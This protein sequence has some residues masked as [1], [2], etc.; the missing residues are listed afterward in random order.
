MWDESKVRIIDIANELGLST[1]TVSNV[2]HGKTK[3][4]SDETVKR[5]ERKLEESGYISN[6]ASTLLARNNSRIIG[7]IINN[8]EKYEGR[9]LQDPFISSAINYL[10]DEIEKNGYF[11]MIKKTKNIMDVVEFASMWNLDGMIVLSFCENEYQDLRDHIRV[12][13]VVYDGFM[14]CPVRISNVTIDDYD[15]GRQVG[16]YL[17]DMG[18]KKVLCIADNDMCMDLERYNG[19]CEGLGYKADF[20]MIPMQKD[21]RMAFYADN[22]KKLREYTAIFAV[23]DYYAVEVMNHLKAAGVKVPDD[24]SIVGYDGSQLCQCVV[25]K[26]TSVWQDN[27]YRAK[28]AME[29]LVKM[30]DNSKFSANVC[31]P[32]K[33]IEGDSVKKI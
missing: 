26:L 29:T 18:H 3:K 13:F 30:I 22:A 21:E 27:A 24:I 10:S 16:Q 11:M 31:V 33:L 17:K 19:L 12:P 7:V 4:I 9:V 20:L 2:L 15:G 6:M 25:P 1:A 23:S 8:H 5:V 28:V 32:V 14:D